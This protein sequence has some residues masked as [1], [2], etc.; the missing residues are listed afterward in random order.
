[1][2]S[3]VWGGVSTEKV[4][5]VTKVGISVVV[6]VMVN[7]RGAAGVRV[8]SGVEY[9]TAVCDLAAENVIAI[10]CSIGIT[11]S[12]V[13]VAPSFIGIKP[14]TLSAPTRKT[15]QQII[16]KDTTIAIWPS[17]PLFRVVVLELILLGCIFAI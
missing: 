13:G 4:E 12:F 7:V 8:E 14:D 16:A 9:D 1:L 17:L 2:A 3:T 11:S 6:G 15:M 5:V 10:I